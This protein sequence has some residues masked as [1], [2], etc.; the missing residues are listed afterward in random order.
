MRYLD[1]ILNMIKRVGMKRK[2]DQDNEKSKKTKEHRWVF[3]FNHNYGN[4]VERGTDNLKWIIHK[5]LV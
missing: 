1:Q 3:K 4:T 5:N 2:L